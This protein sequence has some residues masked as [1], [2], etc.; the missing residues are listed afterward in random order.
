MRVRRD[1]SVVLAERVGAV[2]RPAVR[3]G[4]R[5]ESRAHR[6]LLQTVSGLLLSYSHAR[7]DQQA[8]A[9]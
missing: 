6:V 4:M 2:A 9:R 7:A 1:E 5:G 8:G 3:P